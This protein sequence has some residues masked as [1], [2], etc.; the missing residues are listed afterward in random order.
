MDPVSL[1]MNL[2]NLKTNGVRHITTFPWHPALN[3]LA[4]SAVQTV[5]NGIR[6]IEGGDIQSK[7]TWYLAK[8]R[9]TPQSTTGVSP[10]QLLM[11]RQV[12]TWLDLINPNLSS[13][14]LD[15]QSNQKTHHDY[16]AKDRTLS[17][18][19]PVLCDNFG[20]GD[21]LLPGHILHKPGPMS[22]FV[23]LDDGRY[24]RRH[25]DN[26]RLRSYAVE[27]TESHESGKELFNENTVLPNVTVATSDKESDTIPPLPEK[28]PINTSLG[29][30]PVRRSTRAS[31][32]PDRL[33]L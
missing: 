20:K 32:P 6:C 27:P 16:H 17:V 28:P 18:G 4:E 10:T 11:K 9:I 2:N 3:G 25:Q 1:H 24:I 14:V 26:V 5:K 19:D 33:D 22:Y 31:I 8:Y 12:R 7:V 15:A 30:S 23:K 13:R 29:T 21:K